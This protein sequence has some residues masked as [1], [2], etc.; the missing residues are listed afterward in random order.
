[1]T[2]QLSPESL[3][4]GPDFGTVTLPELQLH[5]TAGICLLEVPEARSEIHHHPPSGHPGSLQFPTASGF[6]ACV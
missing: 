4:P 2:S 3:Q 5:G 1:M 6:L